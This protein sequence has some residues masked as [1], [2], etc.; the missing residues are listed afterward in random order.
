MN[1]INVEKLEFTKLVTPILKN[2]FAN[3]KAMRKLK[4]TDIRKILTTPD[5]GLWEGVVEHMNIVAKE[6]DNRKNI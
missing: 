3:R 2:T 4:N 5:P 6:L 1:T